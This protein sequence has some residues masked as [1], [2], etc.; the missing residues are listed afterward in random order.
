M[1]KASSIT[2]P[3]G[4]YHF[5]QSLH[6]T[7]ASDLVIDASGVEL[8]F[9]LYPSNSSRQPYAT[10]FRLIDCSNVTVRGSQGRPLIIDYQ[11][12]AYW[13]GTIEAIPQSIPN[14]R[15]QLMMAADPDF[16]PL[17]TWWPGYQNAHVTV[18][19]FF[20]GQADQM[21]LLQ[22]AGV[23]TW[24]FDPQT[25]VP[26]NCSFYGLSTRANRTDCS[27]IQDWNF[28][29]Q[30]PAVGDVLTIAP[31]TG[32]TLNIANSSLVTVQDV[33][34]YGS[35]NK[36]ITEFDGHGQHTYRRV[37]IGRRPG[38]NRRLAANSDAFH[39][40][41]T[42]VG[43]T[44]RNCSFSWVGDDFF[45]IHNTLQL[46]LN[47]SDRAIVV[48]EP[49][50]RPDQLALY[51][52]NT[53]YGTAVQFEH[54]KPGFTLSIH[55]PS[56][57]KL[58][59]QMTVA[60]HPSSITDA[61]VIAQAKQLQHVLATRGLDVAE[62]FDVRVWRV[63]VTT[64]TSALQAGDLISMDD[65]S[66]RDASVQ[67]CNFRDTYCTSGR[68]KC[69]GGQ[70]I[71]N[72]FQRAVIHT[73]QLHALPQF[74]EGPIITPNMTF[75]DN[76]LVNCGRAPVTTMMQWTPGLVMKNNSIEV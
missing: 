23:H 57:A 48:V 72:V 5:D 3:A 46:V 69:P 15:P 20:D 17:H 29:W 43:P 6:V 11:P 10:G 40:A 12:A 9:Q 71:G 54:T 66:A 19:I 7:N 73:L 39:S 49:L 45:N 42:Q 51:G 52:Y 70:I 63:P 25:V 76:Q 60:E 26:L 8:Q 67:A 4:I 2:L 65:W 34:I 61:N 74:L 27:M 38:G 50:L 68:I 21:S 53:A 13:Q 33:H 44:L 22:P 14:L 30:R 55:D 56:N 36:A 24:Q 28:D 37:V 1:D 47:A 75:A 41:G 58:K 64:D 32:Y 59:Q 62:A 35:P 31:L 16:P 18:A